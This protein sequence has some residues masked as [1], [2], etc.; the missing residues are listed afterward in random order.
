[1]IYKNK[2]LQGTLACFVTCMVV[3]LFIAEHYEF[4]SSFMPLFVMMGGLI[5]TLTELFTPK[6]LDDNFLMPILTASLLFPIYALII[7]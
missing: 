1:K 2:S 5:P 3:T 4:R 6:S 7:S